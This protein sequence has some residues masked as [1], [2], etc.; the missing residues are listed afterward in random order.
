MNGGQLLIEA[1]CGPIV[2]VITETEMVKKNI[3]IRTDARFYKVPSYQLPYNLQGEYADWKYNQAYNKAI[4][5]NNKRNVLAA[6]LAADYINNEAEGPLAII[7]KRVATSKSTSKTK[8]APSH[9][10]IIKE[11]LLELG[12][13]LPIIHGKTTTKVMSE[14][15]EGLRTNTLKGCISGP[16]VFKEGVDIPNLSGVLLLTAG[17]SSIE[18]IQRLGRALRQAPGKKQPVY[19]D[20]LDDCSWFTGQGIK[21]MGLIKDLYGECITIQSS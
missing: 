7:V 3:I 9:A 5:L 2:K 21:R 4:V 15:F 11:L 13:D 6:K 19:I 17:S 14:V 18:L 20:F 10:E 8:P 1:I 16:G 12:I